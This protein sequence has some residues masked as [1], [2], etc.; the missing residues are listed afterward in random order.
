[1]SFSTLELSLLKFSV[2]DNVTHDNP[3]KKRPQPST[4]SGVWY[5]NYTI[6][7]IL[8]TVRVWL[9]LVCKT[10]KEARASSALRLIVSRYQ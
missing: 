7:E 6:I 2:F 3:L 9:E 4:V 1:M 8:V 10:G 5:S